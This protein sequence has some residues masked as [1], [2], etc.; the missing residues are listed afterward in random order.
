[1]VRKRAA[2]Q[3]MPSTADI[4]DLRTQFVAIYNEAQ[5][6][7]P[8]SES[9][10]EYSVD[11][12]SVEYVT[13]QPKSD[14][15][16]AGVSA[17]QARLDDS[18][19]GPLCGGNLCLDS[20]TSTD[21]VA[22]PMSTTGGAV[23]TT[24]GS[25]DDTSAA[26][27]EDG[28]AIVAGLDDT[29]LYI[30]IGAVGGCLLVTCLI[31]GCVCILRSG[32]DSPAADPTMDFLDEDDPPPPPEDDRNSMLPSRADLM[33]EYVQDLSSTESSSDLGL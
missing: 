9:E 5:T 17:V 15:T 14:A 31:V 10:L 11:G 8:L 25:G 7:D 22:P 12:S 33:V 13:E 16:A 6:G 2:L 1:M 24:V 29:T 30:I 18:D 28:D 23:V 21:V 3:T 27:V 20:V 32:K 19:A 26:A 4:E